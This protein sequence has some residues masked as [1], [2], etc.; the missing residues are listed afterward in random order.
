MLNVKDVIFDINESI[1]HD[2]ILVKKKSLEDLDTLIS[3]SLLHDVIE[4]NLG[5]N[6]NILVTV[7]GLPKI[8]YDYIKLLSK[9]KFN[10]EFSEKKYFDGIL[11]SWITTL[12]KLADRVDNCSTMDVF[13]NSRRK[14]YLTETITHFYPLCSY[15]KTIYPKFSNIITTMKNLIVSF[16]ETIAYSM[17]LPEF[18]SEKNPNNISNFLR[19][20]FTGKNDVDDTIMALFLLGHYSSSSIET[21]NNN[22]FIIHHLKVCSYLI[23]LNINNG[24]IC[25]AA[26]LHEVIAT[27]KL[28]FNGIELVN[29]YHLDPTILG[30]IK[31]ISNTEFYPIDTYYESLKNCLPVLL[32]KLSSIANTCTNLISLSDSEKMNFIHD[33]IQQNQNLGLNQQKLFKPLIFKEKQI[34]QEEDKINKKIKNA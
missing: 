3:V 12:V 27:C 13:D 1:S 9:D 31:I 19:G 20:Y 26:L 23:S 8:V 14:K 17:T 33:Y 25:S 34:K 10:P 2:N 16:T 24:K 6:G 5:K 32:L 22:D 18:I 29:K 11:S 15:A 21:S 4:N 30:Y 7:Y 28:P